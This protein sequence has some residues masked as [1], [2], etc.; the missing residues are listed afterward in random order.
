MRALTDWL[1][2]QRP[3]TPDTAFEAHARLIEIQPFSDGNGRTGRLLMTAV[4]LQGAIRLSWLSRR[5][6]VA[7]SMRSK[8][9]REASG[10]R[11][12]R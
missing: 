12:G 3:S 7:T 6:A 8:P 1:S 2:Q 11:S 5:S 9:V 4:L 10:S